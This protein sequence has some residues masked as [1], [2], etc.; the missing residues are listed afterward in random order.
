MRTFLVSLM[1]VI[2]WCSVCHA[3]T[4]GGIRTNV[5]T[6]INESSAGYWSDA[7]IDGWINDAISIIEGMVGATQAETT[8]TCVNGRIKYVLPGDFWVAEG[9]Y[10][11]KNV[12]VASTQW[13]EPRA[14]VHKRKKE[15]GMWS[16]TDD[17]RTEVYSIWGDSLMLWPTPRATDVVT[18]EYLAQSDPLTTDGADCALDSPL[19]AIVEIYATAKAWAKS[20]D[21]RATKTMD[22]FWMALIQIAG[23]VRAAEETDIAE[24]LKGP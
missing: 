18:L 8:Y 12:A 2:L 19:E 7:E 6:S 3:D 9:A 20:S 4:L 15:I 14:L 13:E 21:A 16:G 17:P 23:I 22:Q 24:S 1:A 10:L 11:K 5:R